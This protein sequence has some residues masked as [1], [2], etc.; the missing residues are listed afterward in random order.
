MPEELRV[1]SAAAKRGEL[2]KGVIPGIELNIGQSVDIPVLVMNG[3]KDGPT[4]LIVSTQHGI[5]IQGI[6]QGNLG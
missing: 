5:E 2:S 6:G 1:G 3:T 4:L